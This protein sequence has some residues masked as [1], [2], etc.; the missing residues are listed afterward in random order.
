M[1]IRHTVVFTFYKTATN[2]QIEEVVDRLNKMGQYLVDELGVTDWVVTKHIPETFKDRR[3]HL[4][5]DGIFPSLEAL[6]AHGS[7][8]VHEKVI[9]LTPKV[10]DWMAIDTVVPEA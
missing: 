5:Q 10:S 3:A 2:E 6:Q 1:K 9:E 8:E 4:L 7:S